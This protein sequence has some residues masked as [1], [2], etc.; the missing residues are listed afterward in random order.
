MSISGDSSDVMADAEVEIDERAT[1][2]LVRWRGVPLGFVRKLK[3]VPRS[4]RGR[5]PPHV[6]VAMKANVGKWHP[7]SGP[8]SY[9]DTPHDAA[10][11]MIEAALRGGAASHSPLLAA[12]IRNDKAEVARLLAEIEQAVHR[13]IDD[14]ST[15]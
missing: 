10:R 8:L 1:T 3:R 12:A 4:R 6:S 5:A 13:A 11:A 7:T 14:A 2:A 15:P 9:H